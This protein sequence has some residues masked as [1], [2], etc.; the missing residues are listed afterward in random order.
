MRFLGK[1]C[2]LVI[3][4]ISQCKNIIMIIKLVTIL[5]NIS[6]SVCLQLNIK[7]S[8]PSFF[9]TSFFSQSVQLLLHSQRRYTFEYDQ[10]D[11]L[12]SVTL[13]SMVRHS[14]QTSLSVGYYRNTYTPP[15]SPTS[16]F[17]QD[18]SHDG[19]LLQSLYLGTGR[20]VIYKYSRVARLAE[21][22][23]DSTL[24]TFTYDEAT[25]AV[26]TIHLM[27]EGFVCTI[28]YRQTG[29]EQQIDSFFT[30][31]QTHISSIGGGHE[32]YVSV[33]VL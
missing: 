29:T 18:Y 28:R 25:G 19:R 20:R 27:H 32:S 14:L 17:T 15:D 30:R 24:V 3:K 2:L 11:C 33:R 12:L 22:L 1:M 5:S 13:P 6:F 16:S 21:I 31:T 10:T 26:K 23:Y 7:V 4:V 8:K 9:I